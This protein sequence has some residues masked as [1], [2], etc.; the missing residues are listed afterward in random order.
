MVLAL[1]YLHIEGVVYRDFKPENI[2]IDSQGYIRLTDFGLSKIGMN[3]DGRTKT[4]CGTLEYMAPEMI[5]NSNYDYSV[6]WFSFGLVLFEM[7]SGRS[8]F[9]FRKD[10]SV[11]QKM[12]IILAEEIRM[13]VHCSAE[14]KDLL[15]K[16]LKY[17]PEN[18]IG[19]W[20]SG[21]LDIKQHP[22]FRG[23][24]WEKLYRKETVPPF[25]PET[26]AAADV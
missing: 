4:F 12:N 6:D 26:N 14:A 20:E 1:E 2:L 11:A 25:I 21:V 18:R 19:C 24:V 9:K 15:A 10:H 22:F 5:K 23:I 17:E 3:E 7:L 13:P 16:L 8:P